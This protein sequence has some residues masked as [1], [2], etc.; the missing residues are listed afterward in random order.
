MQN[1]LL[2][3]TAEAIEAMVDASDKWLRKWAKRLVEYETEEW[4]QAV[5][6]YSRLHEIAIRGKWALLA[7]EK[8]CSIIL[9][10]GMRVCYWDS[11]RSR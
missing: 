2:R 9:S 3:F 11:L 6:F 10:S 8:N 7:A 5:W 1:R 4:D